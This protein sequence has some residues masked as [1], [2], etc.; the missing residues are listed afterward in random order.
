MNND[1]AFVFDTNFIIQNHELELVVQ[2]LNEK[3]FSVYITQVAVDERIAQECNKQKEKYDELEKARH[4]FFDIASIEIK[5]KYE[6]IQRYYKEGMKKKY[7][8][9]FGKNIIPLTVDEDTFSRVLERAYAKT[10]PFIRGSSDKGF[11]DSLMWLSLIDYFT[12]SGEPKVVFVTDDNGFRDNIDI[13][14]KEFSSATGKTIEIK[15]NSYYNEL[16]DPKPEPKQAVEVKYEVD[17]TDLRNEIQETIHDLCWVETEDYWGNTEWYKTFTSCKAF[18]TVYVTQIFEQLE[19]KI[20]SHILETSISA[21]VILDIDN[22]IRDGNAAIPMTALE[23][24]RNLYIKMKRQYI[25]YMQPFYSA[26]IR[27][28]NQNCEYPIDLSDDEELPF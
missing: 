1:T 27:I 3:G 18:D 13:L 9:L 8:G 17:L 5:T 12:K 15:S 25:N 10:P 20:Q 26:T 16:V 4:K 28:L 6:E 21:S 24:A 2:K 22:R 23:R 19:N 14:Q 11:K 7:E